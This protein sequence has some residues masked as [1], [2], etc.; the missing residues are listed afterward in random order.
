VS[1]PEAQELRAPP[2]WRQV[3]FISD[4]HLQA[5]EP[6]TFEAW[7]RFMAATPADALFILGDLFEVWVGDDELLEPGF[8][9]DCADVLR[10]TAARIPV[11]FLHGNRDFLVGAGWAEATGVTLLQD[12]AV[13]AFAGIRWLL[14]HGDALCLDDVDY[15]RF[16]AEV[17]QAAWQRAFLALPLAERRV[18][19]R[20][21][22][23]HS[24]ERKKAGAA[25][26]D[27]DARAALEWMTAARAGTMVHGHTHRPGDHWLDASRRRVVLS[28]WEAEAQPPRLEALRVQ[29]DG[30]VRRVALA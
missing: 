23:G 1:A 16:R 26:A 9:A 11:F 3:D 5:S 15:L 17:R 22:R 30:A 28:D 2:G 10:A 21:M 12:P 25:Y 29:S 13:L 7:R 19:A 18:I 24:E 14:T 4:L 6:S 27:V 8:A 20:G